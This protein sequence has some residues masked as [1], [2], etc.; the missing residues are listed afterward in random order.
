VIA[1]MLAT[2]SNA[3]VVFS[4]NS[5]GWR[6]TL[7]QA[8]R[9]QGMSADGHFYDAD[10][11]YGNF[12]YLMFSA[13]GMTGGLSG[14]VNATTRPIIF[15]FDWVGEGDPPDVVYIK[16]SFSA[17]AYLMLRAPFGS[18]T[19]TVNVPS[20]WISTPYETPLYEF[21]ELYGINK[22]NA[23]FGARLIQKR[24]PGHSFTVQG[25]PSAM[26]IGEAG[27]ST[28]NDPEGYPVTITGT[29]YGFAEVSYSANITDRAVTIVRDG[30]YQWYDGNGVGHGDTVYSFWAKD[31]LTPD[32]PSVNG[33]NFQAIRVG[34]WG[35]PS[36]W[37]W[38][39]GSYLISKTI[40]TVT[41]QMNFG[42]PYLGPY[43]LWYG[44]PTGATSITLN[45]KIVDSDGSTAENAYVLSVHD[46]FEGVESSV[47]PILEEMPSEYNSQYYGP[48]AQ[49]QLPIDEEH[50]VALGGSWS[51]SFG[52]TDISKW[53]PVVGVSYATVP[54]T[55]VRH[56]IWNQPLPE[57][58]HL[59]LWKRVGYNEYTFQYFQYDALGQVRADPS[60]G[61]IKSVSKYREK[62]DE[63]L[64]WKEFDNSG[65]F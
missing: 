9:M 44:S 10:L 32:Q 45:Y 17:N 49:H 28:T 21:G 53:F 38:N 56:A 41:D 30:R 27:Q 24:N 65:G 54:E 19:A 39:G 60:N 55:R 40:D 42:T 48:L 51:F 22:G 61:L 1:T 11:H 52:T 25:S 12:G 43:G 4:E 35:S 20:P 18:G 31:N 15:K 8:G 57:G 14:Y 13:P 58:K 26:A 46:E 37:D 59:R 5:N 29:V 33:V 63:T 7:Q 64:F 16:E 36:S 50:Q 3:Q 62:K 34:N 47:A 23:Q 6:I 2:P